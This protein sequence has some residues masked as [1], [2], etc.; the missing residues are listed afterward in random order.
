MRQFFPFLILLSILSITS[1]TQKYY[2]V[3]HA[4]KAQASDGM[5]MNTPNDPP[6][7]AAGNQRAI[8]L[9]ERL[10]AEKID[11]IFSTNTVRTLTTA[12]GVAADKK[13]EVQQYAKVDSIFLNKLRS[14]KGNVLIVGHSNTVDDLVNGLMGK[15][16]F[17]DLPDSAYDNLFIVLVKGKRLTFLREKYGQPSQ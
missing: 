1:C 10:S 17:K 13:L 15:E 8:A 2:I 11:A 9:K 14:Q 6:L 4:E 7:S 3:R 12:A 5:V 16:E